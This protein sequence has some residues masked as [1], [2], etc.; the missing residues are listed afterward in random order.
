MTL[1]ILELIAQDLL[2]ALQGVQRDQ[3]YNTNLKPERVSTQPE[4]VA[5]GKCVIIQGQPTVEDGPQQK[6]TWRQPFVLKCYVVESDSPGNEYSPDTRINLIRADVE[7]AVR[8]DQGRG[9]FAVNTIIQAPTLYEAAGVSG[10]DINIDVIYR[11]QIN[12]PYQ[13]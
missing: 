3:G 4:V 9:G 7:K 1:P 13:L 2:T 6:Q 10:I 11:T 12:D 5:D 8:A